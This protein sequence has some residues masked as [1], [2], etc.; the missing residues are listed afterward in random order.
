MHIQSGVISHG[1]QSPP[2]AWRRTRACVAAAPAY[3]PLAART[4]TAEPAG[5][6]Q[7][8]A[9]GTVFHLNEGAVAIATSQ[10]SHPLGEL[11]VTSIVRVEPPA[12]S[13]NERTSSESSI[14]N[15]ARMAARP[16]SLIQPSP[17]TAAR[18]RIVC[19]AIGA[20]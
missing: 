12:A 9:R 2:V 7:S 6:E 1:V 19:P 10:V 20:R 17:D 16:Q 11:A 3:A 4:S 5:P 14:G 15:G 18:R 13:P 8:V